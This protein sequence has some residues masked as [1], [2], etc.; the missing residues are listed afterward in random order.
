MTKT[1]EDKIKYLKQ[2]LP[3]AIEIKIMRDS[4]KMYMLQMVTTPTQKLTDM[5]IGGGGN[6]DKIGN[7]VAKLQQLESV[8]NERL[9]YLEG[10]RANIQNSIDSLVDSYERSVMTLRYLDGVKWEHLCVKLNF[11]WRQTHRIHSNALKNIVL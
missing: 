1:N 4:Q 9:S 8:I 10:I 6:N 3:L 2:Y 7:A 11:S 5:P